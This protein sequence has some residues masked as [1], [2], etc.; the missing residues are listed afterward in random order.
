MYHG[1]AASTECEGGSLQL[2]REQFFEQMRYLQ[3]HCNVVRLKDVIER[4]IEKPTSKPNI[5]ITFDDGYMNNYEVAFPVLK[6]LNL[7]ATIFLVT[8]RIGTTQLYWYDKLYAALSFAGMPDDH[9][10]KVID[11]FKVH[12][13]HSI[14]ELVNTYIEDE[15]RLQIPGHAYKCYEVLSRREIEVM[16]S[17]GLITFGSHTHRHELLTM[18]TNNEVEETLLTSHRLM[19][20]EVPN[21]I[22]VFCY[23]NGFHTEIHKQICADIGYQAAVKADSIGGIWDGSVPNFNI[24]RW[25]IWPN[26]D[27]KNFAA[28]V[29]GSFHLLRK[30]AG[31]R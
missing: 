12:H 16:A 3:E 5:I 23:P 15:P 25:G 28:I 7:P 1:V 30:F 22:P 26:F 24:P 31:A 2:N 19:E 18:L 21:Y 4:T 11:S 17:S 6:K 20:Q 27:I 10:L 14:E 8:E 13:P 9:I 29:S